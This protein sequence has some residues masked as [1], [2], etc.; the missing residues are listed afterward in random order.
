ML[1]TYTPTTDL[2]A[3]NAIL[4]AANEAPVESL[5]AA[6]GRG[7]VA[8][9]LAALADAYRDTAIRRWRFNSDTYY[10]LTGT[11]E[12]GAFV[13][14]E[15]DGMLSFTLSRTTEQYGRDIASRPSRTYLVSGESVRIL[16]DRFGGSDTIDL[17]ELFINPVW[18]VD[19]NLMPECARRFIVRSAVRR[20]VQESGLPN[21]QAR[22]ADEAEAWRELR[23]QEGSV[24]KGNLFRDNPGIR[25]VRGRQRG[26]ID[27]RYL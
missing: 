5:D 8:L 6:A 12:A 26:S 16:A 23:E 20:R 22:A 17:P 2:E 10:K 1:D 3:V 24:K 13:Y 18:S 11:T 21:I 4:A 15:P 14:P 7:D 27:L 25:A 9:A 19:F